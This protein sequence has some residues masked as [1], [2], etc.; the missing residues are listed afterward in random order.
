MDSIFRIIAELLGFLR[1]GREAKAKEIDI[2][3]QEEFV[4]REENQREVSQRDADEKLIADAIN[5][6]ELERQ[7]R[8]EEIRRVISK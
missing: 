7:K 2:K 5:S 4:R 1:I 6:K 3:N 8:L